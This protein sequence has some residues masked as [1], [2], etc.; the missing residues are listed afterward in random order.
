M[1]VKPYYHRSP[2]SALKAA[3]LGPGQARMNYNFLAEMYHASTAYQSDYSMWEGLFRLA[4][5]IHDHPLDE[6]ICGEICEKVNQQ[7]AEGDYAGDPV[8][9]LQIARAVLALY[10]YNN[11]RDLLKSVMICC[12]WFS[13]HWDQVISNQVIRRNPADLMEFLVKVYWYTEKKPILSL[14]DKLRREAVNWTGL[15]QTYS[16]KRPTSMMA[17]WLEMRAGIDREADADEGQYVRQYMLTHAETLADGLRATSMNAIYSGSGDEAQAAR[18]GWSKIS[19]WHGAVCGGTTADESVQGNDPSVAIDGASVCAWGEAFLVQFMQG[20]ASWAVEEFDRLLHNG[21]PATIVA[22]RLTP[23]QRV[24]MVEKTPLIREC[25]HTHPSDE[26]RKRV[27]VRLCRVAARAA[28]SVVM[29]TPQGAD[30]ILYVAGEYDFQMHEKAF[31][32]SIK[33]LSETSMQIQMQGKEEVESVIR[34]Y[35]PEWM[36]GAQLAING[37]AQALDVKNG[38]VSLHNTWHHGDVISLVWVPTIRTVETFHQGRA[39]FK[40]NVLM[41]LDVSERD[42]KVAMVGD[43]YYEDGH[44][45][46]KLG[47]VSK[48]EQANGVT[49][50]LPV[51]P[52]VT[53]EVTDAVL[54]PYF[55]APVRLSVFPK[56]VV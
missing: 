48:W 37:R 36:H 47:S 43:P 8:K 56:G 50:P 13:A 40:D 38:F 19:H 35:I 33:R 25:Y 53:G 6:P 3:P 32:A 7:S 21:I 27:L 41:A 52:K 16:I 14:C 42:W 23:Y 24:N 12:S 51:Q 28:S 26:Q 29:T 17:S 20:D 46:V 18:N 54:V 4:C 55:N 1:P 5:I 39:V 49:K 22:G 45:H 34:L 15:L 9:N 31:R 44:V 30:I 2:M 11:S 10:E